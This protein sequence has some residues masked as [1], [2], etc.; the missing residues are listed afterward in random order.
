MAQ[1]ASAEKAAR[2]AEKRNLRNRSAR[3]KM[4]TAIKKIRG[5]KE[6]AK[7][8]TAL[9]KVVKLLDQLA[10]KG[11]IHK[12]KAANQKSALMKFV[13]KLQ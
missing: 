1:H 2:Q 7:A 6:K 3:A 12:N 4:K 8:T 10:A 11:I 5:E 9:T 13:N